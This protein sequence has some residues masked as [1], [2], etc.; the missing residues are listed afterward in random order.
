MC[1]GYARDDVHRIGGPRQGAKNR[2]EIELKLT[3]DATRVRAGFA[4][5]PGDGE[6]ARLVSTYYDTSGGRLWRAGHTLRLR[7]TPAGHELT[8]K[9]AGGD[10]FRRGE[11]TACLDSPVVDPALLPADA[12]AVLALAPPDSLRPW[13]VTDIERVTMRLRQADG[14]L[15]VSLDEGEIQA[16]VHRWPVCEIEIEL[17]EGDDAALFHLARRLLRDHPFHLEARSKFERALALIDDGPPRTVTA[18]VP[19]LDG[20]ASAEQALRRIIGATVRQIVGNLA[21]AADGRDPEG[22]HQLRLGLRRLHAGLG[23]FRP[24]LA[25][26]LR[27]LDKEVEQA[28]K[29]LGPARD[30][31]VFL[32]ETLPAIEKT[33]TGRNAGDVGGLGQLAAHV[34]AQQAIAYAEVRHLVT[35]PAF[36][37][38]VIDLCLA[39]AR[40]GDATLYGSGPVLPIARRRLAKRHRKLIRA[41]KKFRHLTPEERHKLRLKLK[42]LHYAA[43]FFESLFPRKRAQRYIKGL[44]QM[45]KFLGRANDARL[46][47]KLAARLAG[48]TPPPP[49]QAPDGAGRDAG[50]PIAAELG[51]VEAW[52]TYRRAKLEPRLRA[53]WK[54]FRRIRPFW[55]G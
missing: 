55:Q 34:R 15:A 16:G 48:F 7:E 28:L 12:R 42:K 9:S 23:L 52:A 1:P 29:I 38:L 5:L 14:L 43:T 47:P 45:Q 46:A 8:L 37:L 20:R 24:L 22:V 32:Y 54:K 17:L 11:W 13:I 2:L 10:V 40:A 26:A 4:G 25:P 31:D 41:G 3:G 27:S 6:P 51:Q 33:A 18:P 21:A 30:L 53:R 44:S 35:D 49:G 36:S 50:T 39:S 19:R